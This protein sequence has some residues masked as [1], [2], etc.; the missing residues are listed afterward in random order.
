MTLSE[1]YWWV[2]KL[3][4]RIPVKTWSDRRTFNDISLFR[5]HLIVYRL[6]LKALISASMQTPRNLKTAVNSTSVNNI[7][8]C[9]YILPLLVY[10]NK[11]IDTVVSTR[12]NYRPI[13]A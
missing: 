7:P 6:V 13:V 9:I 5:K 2:E 11:Q 1:L 4:V 8:R 10:I 12:D 3:L